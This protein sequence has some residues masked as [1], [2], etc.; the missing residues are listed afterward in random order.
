ML[1]GNWIWLA[2]REKTRESSGNR[3][4]QRLTVGFSAGRAAAVAGVLLVHRFLPWDVADRVDAEKLIFTG[5]FVAALAWA[6]AAR[7]GLKLW[8]R[9]LGLAG[10][11]FVAVTL[12]GGLAARPAVVLAVDLAFLAAGGLLLV[13]AY[14]LHRRPA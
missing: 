10:G 7:D 11:L 8:W 13:V 2:R 14:I 5:L 12:A 3:L 9:Q 4:L 1:S 6:V